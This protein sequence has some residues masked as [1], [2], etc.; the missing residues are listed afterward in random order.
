MTA[1]I[2]AEKVMLMCPVKTATFYDLWMDLGKHTRVTM[3]RMYTF[4]R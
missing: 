1:L 4:T 2:L 3:V